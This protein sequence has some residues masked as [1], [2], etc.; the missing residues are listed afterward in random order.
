M[1][2]VWD[3]T[4]FFVLCRLSL[5][6]HGLCDKN[7][8]TCVLHCYINSTLDL[9]LYGWIRWIG[10]HPDL[11][12]LVLYC[13]ADLAGDRTDSKSTSGVFMCFLG[14]RSFMPLNALS[15]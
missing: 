3:D 11:L 2:L 13:D 1:V 12:E 4:I 5:M 14:P 10:D 9:N 15:I 8:S 7:P 6:W